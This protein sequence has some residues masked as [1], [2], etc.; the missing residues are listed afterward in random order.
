MTEEKILESIHRLDGNI[1]TSARFVPNSLKPILGLPP[2]LYEALNYTHFLHSLAVNPDKVIPAGKSL[3]SVLTKPNT[4]D[5]VSS[6]IH[7]R[8]ETIV[9]QA[10]WDEVR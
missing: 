2:E 9:H 8:V 3:L 5:Q 7:K 10:F 1:E 4:L 6:D